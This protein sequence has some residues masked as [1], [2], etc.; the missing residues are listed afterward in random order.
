M[1]IYNPPSL[2]L[3]A[4]QSLLLSEASSISTLEYLPHNLFPPVFKEAFTG[5]HMQLLKAMVAAWP[6]S[7]LPVGSLTKTPD[8]ELLQAILGGIDVLQAQKVRPR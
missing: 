6:F 8:V 7:Y 4:M 5:K 2:Q 3:L 1:S